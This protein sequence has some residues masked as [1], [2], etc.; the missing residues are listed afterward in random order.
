M[1]SKT[2]LQYPMQLLKNHWLVWLEFSLLHPTTKM[3]DSRSSKEGSAEGGQGSATWSSSPTDDSSHSS[4]S[5][6]T[7]SQSRVDNKKNY[8]H[9]VNPIT[10]RVYNLI[11]TIYLNFSTIGLTRSVRKKWSNKCSSCKCYRKVAIDELI[12]T[13]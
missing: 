3:A 13:R 1:N 9:N 7:F 11:C 12:F 6:V 4:P 2:N 5:K 8:G 10:N